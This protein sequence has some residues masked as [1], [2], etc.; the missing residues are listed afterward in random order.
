MSV[1][2]NTDTTTVVITDYSSSA[3]TIVDN[4]AGSSTVNTTSTSPSRVTV[5]DSTL[6]AVSDVAGNLSVSGT[7]TANAIEPS[8]IYIP[9][10][11]AIYGT[12]SGGNKFNIIAQ[13]MADSFMQFGSDGN[14]ITKL[15]GQEI[16]I[17]K[18]NGSST[19]K[20]LGTVTGNI[21]ASGN[22]SSS[23]TGV[24]NELQ[25][26]QYI[27]SIAFPNTSFEFLNN[28]I[29][30][31]SGAYRHLLL[32]HIN[33]S[34]LG[35]TSSP[36]TVQGSSITL[37]GPVTASGNISASSDI[38]ASNFTTPKGGQLNVNRGQI[39]STANSDTLFI[40]GTDSSNI[41]FNDN[42]SDVDIKIRG[43][44]GNYYFKADADVE[45]VGI[46]GDWHTAVPGQELTVHGNISASGTIHANDL[47]L[48]YDTLPTSD[49]SNK[50]QVYRSGGALYISAG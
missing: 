10:G 32:D 48:D 28:T 44:N 3:L 5:S 23:G 22:I 41:T 40:D 7:V 9:F 21:T 45:K 17:G 27:K 50:G 11:G 16:T 34:A 33:G 31:F 6:V 42:E 8:T 12:D 1:T 47:I 15:R 20:L 13:N 19:I 24:F 38:Q 49:P 18:A 37:T 25:V 35:I 43:A 2:L 29:R 36:V 14:S 46:G 26:S 4:T 30:G 39:R